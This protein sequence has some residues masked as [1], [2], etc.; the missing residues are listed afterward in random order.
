MDHLAQSVTVVLDVIMRVPPL[1]I[2]DE[3]LK[4]DF[5]LSMGSA[6][7]KMHYA[8]QTLTDY[9]MSSVPDANLGNLSSQPFNAQLVIDT[10]VYHFCLSVALKFFA[11]CFG[12]KRCR[13]VAN[14]AGSAIF[15][16]FIGIR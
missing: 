8:N 1:F 6:E 5:G 2:I 12:E 3:L 15:C 4:I 10:Y 16:L 11:C 14:E 9:S 13:G 7:P